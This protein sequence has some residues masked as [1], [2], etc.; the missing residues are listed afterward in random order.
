MSRVPSK[1]PAENVQRRLARTQIDTRHLTFRVVIREL[2]SP[3][4]SA[5]PDIETASG[6]LQ[7][8]EEQPIAKREP[9]DVILEV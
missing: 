9:K 6:I 4:T 5:R 2:H 1:T 7:R 8:R 3:D